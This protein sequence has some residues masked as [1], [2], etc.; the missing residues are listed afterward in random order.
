MSTVTEVQVA[1]SPLTRYA[2]SLFPFAIA[3]IGG[4]QLV[5]DNPGNWVIVIQFAI[6]IVGSF[7]AYLLKL[8]PARW[9]GAAKTG[10]QIGAAVLAALVPFILPGGFD[11]AVNA[12][13]VI[14]GVL[15][16]LATE[17]GVQIRRDAYRL[18]A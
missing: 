9:A 6:L 8:V 5:L 4:L 12:T 2:A 14:I 7:V 18:A 13:A 16:A 11:P 17:F 10:A 3:V 1:E 15:N